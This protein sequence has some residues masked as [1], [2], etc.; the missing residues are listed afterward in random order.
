MWFLNTPADLCRMVQFEA[1]RISICIF[2]YV[3]Q[4]FGRNLDYL[5]QRLASGA[6]CKQMTVLVLGGGN[7]T[8]LDRPI[9]W[10]NIGP[11]IHGVD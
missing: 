6:E 7:F 4:D 9:R 5:W 1:V 2:S 3:L 10:Y 8:E 11:F